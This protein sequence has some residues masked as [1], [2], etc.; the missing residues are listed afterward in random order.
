MKFLKLEW[1]NI[2][3][4]GDE[5][6]SVD[7]G[8]ASR[9]W[10][11]SGKVGSGKSSL[12]SVPKLLLYGKTEGSDGKAVPTG[13][14]AN[15]TNKRGWIRGTIQKGKDLWIVE[16]T[17]SPSGLSLFKNGDVVDKAGLKNLQDTIDSEILDGMPYTIF[18][19]VVT[20]SLNNFKSFISLS[21][22]DK[23]AIID[24]IFSLDVI[25]KVHE[26]VKVDMKNIGNSINSSNSQIYVYEQT[27]KT[28][29]QE[30][31]SIKSGK[32][33]A[34]GERL[35]AIRISLEKVSELNNQQSALY[36]QTYNTYTEIQKNESL[37]MR[38]RAVAENELRN[39]N[40]QIELFNMDRCPTCGTPLAGE[41]FDAI[42]NS[43][44]ETKIA[45]EE[46]ISLFNE[47]LNV[48]YENRTKCQNDMLKIQENINK[49]QRKAS[50][51]SSEYSS[52]E[53]VKNSLSESESIKNIIKINQESKE[54]V[55]QS[56]KS[57]NE[58]MK[59]L[60]ILEELYSADGIKKQIMET[61]IPALNEEVAETLNILNFPYTLTFDAN[62][63]AKLGDMDGEVK[64][65]SLSIG[66]HKEV[67][68]AVL[69]SIL[70]MV[71]KKYPQINLVFLDETVSSLDYESSTEII[72]HLKEIS[73]K[74]GL[75]IFIV[76]HTTLDENLFDVHLSVEKKYGY[77]ILSAN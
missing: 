67:D 40:N 41:G 22:A 4:Y 47:N 14:I 33:S 68:I 65:Q 13:D 39:V 5:I 6:T 45:I 19:N 59:T 46:K 27:I 54:K 76:S 29:L 61:Y 71:K 66:E 35:A 70:K 43:L 15:R 72:K 16:R 26:L 25:N 69:C 20:L 34:S 28:S 38:E 36:N 49:I 48:L 44:N 7:I 31:E 42:R 77:S 55:E 37:V 10:Q 17:F 64:P 52:I 75:N 21:A 2:F 9:L 11:L 73:T 50:E 56:I 51:L 30:I 63:D 1:K 18:A 60:T 24:K 8:D 12:L 74:M 58:E 53:A 32:I 62:F 57:L 23:R 3:S